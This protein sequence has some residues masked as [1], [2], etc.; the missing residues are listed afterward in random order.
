MGNHTQT[1]L[2]FGSFSKYI[3]RDKKK[4]KRKGNLRDIPKQLPCANYFGSDPNAGYFMILRN[5]IN[6]GGNFYL[7][8][9]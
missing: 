7:T 6:L 1:I 8:I 9:F 3:S 5:Y 2:A 4:K